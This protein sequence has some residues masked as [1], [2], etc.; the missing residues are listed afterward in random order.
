M[1]LLLSDMLHL[2]LLLC[3]E[4]CIELWVRSDN[5]SLEKWIKHEWQNRR[6]LEDI[7]IHIKVH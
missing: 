7:R 3:L 4:K 6:T 1:L 2:R 5:T